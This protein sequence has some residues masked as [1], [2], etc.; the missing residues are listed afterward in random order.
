M[1][2]R[3]IAGEMTQ[4]QMAAIIEGFIY[5]SRS[6]VIASDAPPAATGY[7]VKPTQQVNILFPQG[8]N[9]IAST[10]RWWLVPH[11]FKG[12][13]EEWKAT[14]FNAKIETAHEKPTF[15]EAWYHARCVIPALGYYEWSGP[16]S[17]RQPNY[18]S[19][20]QNDPLTLFAGLRSTLADGC[21]TC[22]ILTRPALPEIHDLHPRMPVL[23]SADEA[24]QW[25]D[26][27]AP[28]EEIRAAFGTHWTGR[29][30]TH[31]V[32]KFG[33]KDDGPRLIEPVG[34]GSFDFRD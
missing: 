7:N 18:I 24:A 26:H 19:L 3:L 13:A 4:A 33:M 29:F 21:E 16:K 32:A 25:M 31:Q 8:G 27:S 1:C 14:T 12:P 23:L 5:P 11:W 22:T 34:T 9:L 30:Q 2:G 6:V 17:D 28:D 15:R 20:Q 10:A